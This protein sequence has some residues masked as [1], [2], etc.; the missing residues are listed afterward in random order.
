MGRASPKAEPRVKC[1]PRPGRAGAHDSGSEGA[2]GDQ[3]A[4]TA[5]FSTAQGWHVLFLLKGLWEDLEISRKAP[6]LYFMK[7]IQPQTRVHSPSAIS[8]LLSDRVLIH[9]Y[10]SYKWL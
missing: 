2:P 9:V 4:G 3:C 7:S 10:N 5:G 1:G 6:L 8:I